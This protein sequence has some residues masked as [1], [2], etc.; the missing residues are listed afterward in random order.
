MVVIIPVLDIINGLVVHA[1][2]GKRN[3]YRPL[4][5]SVITNTPN[6]INVLTGLKKLG[7]KY[8]YI[9]DIDAITGRRSNEFVIDIA[10][11]NEFN[12][13]ADIGRQGLE[14]K[15]TTRLTYVIGT[16]YIDFPDEIDFLR[17]RIVSLDIKHGVSV[18]RNTELNVIRAA[19]AICDNNP[20]MIIVLNLDRVGTSSGIDITTVNRVKNVC[21]TD[22][23][24]GG[25]LRSIDEIELI[26]KLDVKYV[27]TATAIHKGIIDKC[28]Y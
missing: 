20:K 22:I 18:F 2:A 14:K 28:M 3:E 21:N 15:D 17:G 11:A 24:V 25:G 23:A 6:P 26:K 8:V 27:L 10:L 4:T 13:L 7:C 9:A 16:E 12:V 5:S 1:V 19:K